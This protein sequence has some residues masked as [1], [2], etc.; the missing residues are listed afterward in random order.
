MIWFAT[1]FSIH[2]SI[3]SSTEVSRRLQRDSVRGGRGRRARPRRRPPPRAS[4]PAPRPCRRPASGPLWCVAPTGRLSRDTPRTTCRGLSLFWYRDHRDHRDQA[5]NWAVPIAVFEFKL[6]TGQQ[7]AVVP[8]R[9]FVPGSPGSPTGITRHRAR[10]AGLGQRT[11]RHVARPDGSSGLGWLSP[12][13]TR[14]RWTSPWP[15]SLPG[16]IG[17]RSARPGRPASSARPGRRAPRPGQRCP[18]GAA[19][20]PPRRPLRGAGRRRRAEVPGLRGPD[21]PRRALLR[22]G[23]QAEQDPVLPM[24]V[25]LL[26]VR[27]LAAR[28]RTW[29]ARTN[30]NQSSAAG[31]RPGQD[32]PVGSGPRR[33]TLPTI[34]R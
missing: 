11:G 27:L 32:G 28:A 4:A 12:G 3:L 20:G 9:P 8:V 10:S 29:P 34:D 19:R 7:L 14:S 6:T 22:A 2:R 21:P 24:H 25:R 18:P 31:Q 17:R 13:E 33:L 15:T 30:G 26:I 16:S 5:L 23:Q 1:S